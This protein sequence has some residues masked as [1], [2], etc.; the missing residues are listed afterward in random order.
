MIE[1]KDLL[2]LLGRELEY[3]RDQPE[4]FRHFIEQEKW[5]TEQIEK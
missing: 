3:G 1:I 5:S 4:R 2:D